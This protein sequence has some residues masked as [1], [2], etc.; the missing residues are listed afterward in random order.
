[1][2]GSRS[3]DVCW[4]LPRTL[5][6]DPMKLPSS[7]LEPP[8]RATARPLGSPLGSPRRCV[9]DASR[10]LLQLTSR[11][12][13]PDRS[14][15]FRASRLAPRRPVSASKA[16]RRAEAHLCPSAATGA[17]PPCGNPTPDELALDGANTA[18]VL[19]IASLRSPWRTAAGPPKFPGCRTRRGVFDRERDRRKR[20]LTLPVAPR[21]TCQA[22][23]RHPLRGTRTASTALAS[24]RAA[25][26]AQSAFRRRVLERPFRDPRARH[27]SHGFAAALR[28]PT[29]LRLPDALA[30]E[31]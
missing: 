9:K 8:S 20:P 5:S 21:R 23:A 26:P 16:T 17:G 6:P 10:R 1:M 27:R 3:L 15:E 4:T 18:S 30:R 31:G 19:S 13:H 14:P 24:T 22:R 12:E 28:L 11:N 2:R 7:G 25:F 29:L